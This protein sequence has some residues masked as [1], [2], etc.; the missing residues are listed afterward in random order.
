MTTPTR[1]RGKGGRSCATCA[2]PVALKADIAARARRGDSL[3]SISAHVVNEGYG[4]GRAGIT[5]HLRQCVGITEQPEDQGPQLASVI[6]AHIV[7]DET[8]GW[9]N[10]GTRVANR[11]AEAGLHDEAAIVLGEVPEL[12]RRGLM[13]ADGGSSPA[14]ELLSA[15][16]LAQ[17]IRQVL[18]RRHPEASRD[19]AA[20]CQEQGAHDLADSLLFLADEA[21]KSIANPM[22]DDER[23]ERRSRVLGLWAI[24]R[25]PNPEYRSRSMALFQHE[26]GPVRL[27]EL[28]EAK[29][30]AQAKSATP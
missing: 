20:Q 29:A 18:S 27:D 14:A 23:W 26:H 19:L 2:L 25:E 8:T 11:L 22:T 1:R 28:A 24:E 4:I 3:T 17:A 7:R 10:V 12:L 9:P 15:R 30:M 6:T 13:D 16:L 5:L 21:D